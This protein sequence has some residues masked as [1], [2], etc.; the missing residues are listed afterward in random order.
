MS[1]FYND[2]YNFRLKFVVFAR[3]TKI[4]TWT[5]LSVLCWTNA[6]AQKDTVIQHTLDSIRISSDYPG[7]VF[8]FIDSDKN[9]HAFASGWAD[10]EQ[11]IKMTVDHKL[12]GGSTGKT[13]VS[14]IIMQL[15]EEGEITLDDSISQYLGKYN[16]YSRL[17]NT[18]QITIKNL[19][20][21][22]SGIV[23]YEFKEAFLNDLTK[24]PD[25]VWKP[26]ELLAYVLDDEPPFEPG[27]GFT[28]SDTNYILLG[29]II[30]QVTGN[31]FYKEAEE[32]V[33][34]PL[35]IESFSPTNNNQIDNMAQGYYDE[36]TDYALGFKAP[37]LVDGKAQNNTQFEWTGG[38]YAYKNSD[39]AKLLI[40]IYEGELFDMEALGNAFFDFVEAEEIRGKYGLGV[41]RYEYPEIGELIGHSGFF[42]GYYTMGFYHPET[43]QAFT[44]QVNCTLMPQL[45][46]FRDDYLRLIR[47]SLSFK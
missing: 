15:I 13:V 10:K 20:Q 9:V 12:H 40:A 5:I 34:T 23:R 11:G 2:L 14:A 26:E 31:T 1:I 38:G 29:M 30:E 6:F 37:F 19:L 7:I 22:T 25:K 4:L 46:N 32:R 21:H 17:A 44:M 27:R 24:D 16:W 28:Y 41:I 8:T 36:G 47:L 42:P 18:D 35:G 3:M 45:K 39:Y 33:F 43:D